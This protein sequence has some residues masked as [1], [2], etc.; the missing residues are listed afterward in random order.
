MFLNGPTA[1]LG[2]ATAGVPGLKP[3]WSEY[4]SAIGLPLLP[5]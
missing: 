2:V 5:Q 1:M 4:N 3:S